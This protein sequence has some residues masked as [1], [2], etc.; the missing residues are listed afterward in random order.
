VNKIKLKIPA[1]INLTLD[2]CGRERSYHKI[3]SLVTSID[4]Y[5]TI[6]VKKRKDGVVTLRE[7]GLLA[8]C[9]VVDNNA[10]KAAKLFMQTFHTT[11]VDIT[12]EKHIPVAGGLGGSSADVA[13][14]LIAMNHL[15]K[16]GGALKPLAEK[17]SSDGGYMLHGGYCLL[18]GRGEQIEKLDLSTKLYAIIVTDKQGMTAK[19]AYKI[20]DDL[21]LHDF[22]CTDDAVMLLKK[23]DVS[24]FCKIAKN[25]LYNATI[26]KIPELKDTIAKLI[27]A[28]A[29]TALMSGSGASCYGIYTNKK[30]MLVAYNYLCAY[31]SPDRLIM[32]KT[33]KGVDKKYTK[34]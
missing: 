8:G 15:Y 24:E 9:S 33:C 28:D 29:M 30:E 26:T 25:D 2:V 1:K 18:R 16:V 19:E 23:G 34:I 6:T 32:T 13:G 22:E 14:V 31:I 3:N 21:D 20:Y 10:F 27:E 5:D 12:I 17:I 11:G 4:V 7:K